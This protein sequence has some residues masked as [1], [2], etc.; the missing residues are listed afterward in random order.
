MSSKDSVV[1]RFALSYRKLLGHDKGR[2]ELCLKVS[3]QIQ[4]LSF[5]QSMG[6][7]IWAC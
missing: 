5:R 4:L 7:Y 3:N 1:E 6:T 2:H